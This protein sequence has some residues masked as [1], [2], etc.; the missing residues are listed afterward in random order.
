MK[1]ALDDRFQGKNDHMGD[2]CQIGNAQGRVR[3]YA[4]LLTPPS[5]SKAKFQSIQQSAA[6]TMAVAPGGFQVIPGGGF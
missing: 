5:E 4:S 2:A 3:H 6:I 1:L